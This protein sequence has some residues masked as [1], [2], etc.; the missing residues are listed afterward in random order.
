MLPLQSNPPL[1]CN[2]IFFILYYA[3]VHCWKESSGMSLSS[4]VEALQAFK[5][6]SLDNPLEL[7]EKKKVAWRKTRLKGRLFQFV[8]GQEMVDVQG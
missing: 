5:M 2:T 6:F 4:T 7:G 8:L 3:S 1:E